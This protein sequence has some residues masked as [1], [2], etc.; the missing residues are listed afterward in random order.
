[1]SPTLRLMTRVTHRGIASSTVSFAVDPQ[2]TQRRATRY[3]HPMGRKKQPKYEGP[4]QK[5]PK[6]ETI[7][8]PKRGEIMD[9]LRKIA[10]PVKG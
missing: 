5:T 9:A 6:G 7:P 4:T 1:M 3:S 10:R 2:K 8:L